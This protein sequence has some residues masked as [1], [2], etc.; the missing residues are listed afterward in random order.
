M[1]RKVRNIEVSGRRYVWWHT[2]SDG[3]VIIVSPKG[4]RTSQARVQF[5]CMGQRLP[6]NEAAIGEFPGNMTLSRNGEVQRIRTLSPG[7]VSLIISA[8]PQDSLKSRRTVTLDDYELL[9]SYGFT[10]NDIKNEYYW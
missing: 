8:L 2:F 3:A 1:R 10:V 7:M 5:Q 9:R 6:E 4:D